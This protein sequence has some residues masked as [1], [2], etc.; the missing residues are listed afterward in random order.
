MLFRTVPHLTSH[1]TFIDFNTILTR[2]IDF[3]IGLLLSVDIKK[4]A[5][6]LLKLAQ[7]P[8]TKSDLMFALQESILFT[9]AREFQIGVASKHSTKFFFQDF[10]EFTETI[11]ECLKREKSWSVQPLEDFFIRLKFMAKKQSRAKDTFFFWI[12]HAKLLRQLLKK[13]TKLFE[14]LGKG[15]KEVKAKR[16]L[17]LK[18]LEEE[19]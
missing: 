5:V 10:T 18:Q 8:D 19:Y 12:A 9:L 11:T 3:C 7:E 13:M 6:A 4:R 1:L 16:D 2:Y 17:K 15:S 14:F